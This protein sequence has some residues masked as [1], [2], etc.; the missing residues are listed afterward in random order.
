MDVHYG[1]MQHMWG[2]IR[3]FISESRLE[4]QRECHSRVHLYRG[5]AIKHWHRHAEECCSTG[6]TGGR[7][8]CL[9]RYSF[10][11]VLGGRTGGLDGFPRCRLLS[12]KTDAAGEDALCRT[13]VEM[14]QSVLLICTKNQE[15]VS[16]YE[17]EMLQSL[18][19]SVLW[20]FSGYEAS[21]SSLINI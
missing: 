7:E 15:C 18:H 20:D 10:H 4:E 14:H 1:W 13:T 9:L 11:S 16:P 8:R 19:E 3:L 12:S 6:N 2:K 17:R 5:S 21:G